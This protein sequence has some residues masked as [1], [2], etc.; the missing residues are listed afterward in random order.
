MPHLPADLVEALRISPS[1]PDHWATVL[2]RSG[3]NAVA[4]A[5]KRGEDSAGFPIDRDTVAVV[6]ATTIFSCK[7]HESPVVLLC[8]TEDLDNLET[9]LTDSFRGADA[10][11]VERRKRCLFYVGAT[12]AMVRQYVLGLD[13]SRFLRVARAYAALMSGDVGEPGLLPAVGEGGPVRAGQAARAEAAAP[14][15]PPF[16]P[17]VDP[18]IAGEEVVVQ[19]RKKFHRRNCIHLSP[20]A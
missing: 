4:F 18:P 20:A 6:R 1:K 15:T 9:I 5:G 2:G 14:P 3:I 10:R 13:T 11:V 8:G 7:G 12:R 16:P 19:G 17:I